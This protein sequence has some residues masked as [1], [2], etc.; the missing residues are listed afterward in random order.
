MSLEVVILAAGKGTRM[1]SKTPKVLHPLAGKP[2]LAHVIDTALRLSPKNIHVVYGYENEQVKQTLASNAVNWVMQKEQLGTAHALLQALPHLS[3]ASK[4]LVLCGDVPLIS[5]ETLE[6]LVH[7]R[8]EEALTLLTAQVTHPFGLGR[9]IRDENNHLIAII[10]ERDAN[11]DQKAINEI[12][13]GI[14][15]ATSDLLHRHCHS[16]SNNNAQGEFYLTSIVEKAISEDEKVGALT[17]NNENEII[18]INNKQQLCEA[19]RLY[20]AQQAK[21]LFVQGVTLADSQRIDIRGELNCGLDV[22]IDANTIFEGR[23]TIEDDVVIE[24]NCVIKDTHIRRGAR[25]HSHSNIEGADIGELSSIGPFARIRQGTVV[26]QGCKIGNFVETKKIL[27]NAG[28]K[29]SHLSYLGDCIIGSEVN[30]GA[31]TITCNYDGANKHQTTIEDGAFIGSGTQLVAPIH[32][33]PNATIGAGT[34]LRRSAPG[35]NLTLTDKPQ[36]TIEGW[37]RP[38]KK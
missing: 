10:E 34:T 4:V 3:K 2:M 36:R 24:A 33:G 9:I 28:S 6:K 15:C 12:Y 23:V 1:Y 20:Q 16:L 32:I 11:Q 37:Q 5:F 29:A 30:I 13:S 14:M 22:F 21:K 26:K 35:G 18:G 7:P 38:K 17:T 19:E 27:L 31:G 25:I 8:R